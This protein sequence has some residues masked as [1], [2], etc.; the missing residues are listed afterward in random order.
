MTLKLQGL[1][2][3]G[4]G[5]CQND[6][7]V[8]E[9]IKCGLTFNHTYW[10]T[11]QTLKVYGAPD[12]LVNTGS[13]TMFIK[14]AAS[15][16][17]QYHSAWNS[18]SMPNVLVTVDDLDK[19]VVSGECR[20]YNDPHMK[21]FDGK[22][23]ENQRIGEFVLY[24][25][26][27]RPYWVHALYQ[28]CSIRNP[29]GVTCN[30]GV[31]VRNNRDLF[32]VNFCRASIGWTVNTGTKSNR[33]IEKSFCDDSA[34]TIQ[35]YGNT[36]TV[37]LPT[38]TKIVFTFY[39]PYGISYISV[40]PSLADWKSSSGLCGFM[41]GNH[42]NDF[43]LRDGS[44]A[45]SLRDFALD[46]KINDV[47]QSLFQKHVNLADSGVMLRQFCT[48]SD[49]DF[50]NNIKC[51]PNMEANP[52]ITQ[53]TDGF[54]KTCDSI[55][56][57]RSATSAL[58]RYKREEPETD[59]IPKF[60]IVFEDDI[61]DEPQALSW[62]NGWDIVKAR[63]ACIAFLT[64]RTFLRKCQEVLP[65]LVSDVDEGVASCIEDIRLTGDTEYMGTTAATLATSCR[66]LAVKL[67]NLTKTESENGTSGKSILDDM[68][69]LDC[70]NNCTGHGD[71]ENGTCVCTG[72]Y[73]GVEC[74]LLRTLPPIVSTETNPGLCA[75]DRYPCNTFY[76]SGDNFAPTSVTCKAVHFSI[77]AGAGYTLDS[78]NETFPA[79][80]LAGGIGC[81]CTVPQSLRR[82]RSIDADTILADGFFLSVSNDGTTFSEDIVVIKYDSS[83]YTCN[84]TAVTCSQLRSC[85]TTISSS[86][87]TEIPFTTTTNTALPTTTTSTSSSKL[88]IITSPTTTTTPN[89]PTTPTATTRPTTKLTQSTITTPAATN[90][91][92]TNTRPLTTTSLTATTTPSITTTNSS[93]H[94]PFTT[95]AQPISTKLS[96]ITTTTNITS[97]T[98]STTHPITTKSPLTTTSPTTTKAP[99]TNTPT[100]STTPITTT[101]PSTPTTPITTTTT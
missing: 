67:E 35:N 17:V 40:K 70:P 11:E 101:T 24:K 47:S 95:T 36:Y 41:D 13:R 50:T 8:L 82:K 99:T 87:T 9:D 56:K 7:I 96:T 20:S 89:A 1:K 86:S 88:S 71:C 54:F 10:D 46:W 2:Q 92:T 15:D 60:Q 19:T 83:C 33:Y 65:S 76:I 100:T 30:C 3:G 90:K 79:D 4:N 29:N 57:K 59:V 69:A 74:S 64:A 62:R 44:T 28:P 42:G 27:Q 22:R 84:S 73:E 31:A 45:R 81:A 34:M 23:W 72:G 80:A 21:T 32:V 98:P 51:S 75:T 85:Q 68:L 91:R 66:L 97:T 25:H 49:S 78:N 37:V 94:A 93:T 14:M 18:A 61:D 58:Q 48:C 77:T 6:P 5:Q 55:R 38:G 26:N 53:S 63:L 43:I 16:F 12:N 52:C 39:I